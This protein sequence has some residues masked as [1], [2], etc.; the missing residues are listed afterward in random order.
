MSNASDRVGRRIRHKPFPRQILVSASLVRL[1]ATRVPRHA[2]STPPCFE[3]D[4]NHCPLSAEQSGEDDAESLL[5]HLARHA[6]AAGPDVLRI[7]TTAEHASLS[8]HVE[9][10]QYDWLVMAPTLIPCGWNTFS[11]ASRN[12]F[13][14]RRRYPCW[15]PVSG[16][17]QWTLMDRRK[18]VFFGPFGG[19]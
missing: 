19:V 9:K 14:C 2:S 12:P 8:E 13:S 15:I 10:G 1:H 17:S 4:L 11:V 18:R 6:V 7:R 16:V 5:A 3:A